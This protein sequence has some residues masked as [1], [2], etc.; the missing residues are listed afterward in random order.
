MKQQTNKLIVL[1]GLSERYDP[2]DKI[3]SHVGATMFPRHPIVNLHS[4]QRILEQD[5]LMVNVAPMTIN[6][7][8]IF[9]H[10]KFL[11]GFHTVVLD[12]PNSTM[13]DRGKWIDPSWQRIVVT[14]RKGYSYPV[15]RKNY[16]PFD[17]WSEYTP[18]ELKFHNL[19]Q[20]Y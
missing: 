17:A 12:A 20:H 7:V 15:E 6:L 3:I 8:K 9:I 19:V 2:V 16:I 11:E 13:A 4:I 10:A 14:E 18:A 5:P 1:A